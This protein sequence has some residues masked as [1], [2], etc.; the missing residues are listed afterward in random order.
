MNVEIITSSP[1]IGGVKSEAL[2]LTNAMAR[3][4]DN[5]VDSMDYIKGLIER[6]VNVYCNQLRSNVVTKGAMYKC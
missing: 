4:N 3:L 6:T 2:S 1:A 5:S